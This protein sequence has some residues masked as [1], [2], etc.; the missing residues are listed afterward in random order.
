MMP[1]Q[2]AGQQ[3]EFV[4][5]RLEADS[6]IPSL[7][8][9][10]DE[11]L[12][13]LSDE[14]MGFRELA[15]TVSHFP[16]ICSRLIFLANSAWA[17]PMEAIADLERVCARLGFSLVRSIS[18]A[19]VISSAFDVSRCPG[20]SPE[21]Y[22]TSSL[23]SARLLPILKKRTRIEPDSTLETVSTACLLHNIGLLWLADNLPAE[24]A[25][26]LSGYDANPQKSLRDN[27]LD[28][29]DL[30]F[31]V[32]GACMASAWG[33]PQSLVLAM[34][35]QFDADYS[36]ELQN[37]V[38]LVGASTCLVADLHHSNC[39]ER[40][41]RLED[42]GVNDSEVESLIEFMIVQER[43]LG[44]MAKSLFC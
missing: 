25:K 11:L 30:D 14:K 32:V 40:D 20:F 9:A 31:G 1:E 15:H 27:L 24:T 17:S 41:K 4:M 8:Y 42:L 6:S 18:I 39:E 13:S 28:V 34:E 3:R 38:K 44:D 23:L 16:D 21:R 5:R 19:M 22:W 7:P 10:V 12:D 43:I 37:D 26:A 36:G 29:C 2:A 33:F 35:H